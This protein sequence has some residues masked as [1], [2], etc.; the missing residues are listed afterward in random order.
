MRT[1]K[2]MKNVV[3]CKQRL[4]LNDELAR[5]ALDQQVQTRLHQILLKNEKKRKK[6][7]TML[8]TTKGVKTTLSTF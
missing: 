8:M 3:Q 4:M 7:K 2:K 6:K 1:T 5:K